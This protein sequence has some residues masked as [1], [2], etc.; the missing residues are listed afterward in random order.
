[1]IGEF[2]FGMGIQPKCQKSDV[3]VNRSI[4]S[5]GNRR[6]SGRMSLDVMDKNL[7]FSRDSTRNEV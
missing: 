4:P 6:M 2:E 3:S 7:I 1:M 5:R